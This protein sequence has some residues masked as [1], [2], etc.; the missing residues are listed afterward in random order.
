MLLLGTETKLHNLQKLQ[1][2]AISLIHSATINDTIP[3]ATPSVKE[4]IK[5][6]QAVMVH[7][8][9][10]EQCPKILNEKFKK[11]SQIQHTK[12]EDQMT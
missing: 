9:L 11:R 5:F 10:N 12:H 7:N 3:F 4:F 6:D 8:I 2:I 1:D